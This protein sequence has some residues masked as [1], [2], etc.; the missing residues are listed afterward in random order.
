[1]NAVLKLQNPNTHESVIFSI[2]GLNEIIAEKDG[3]IEEQKNKIEKQSKN[4]EEKDK[5][6]EEQSIEIKDLKDKLSL[7]SENSSLP[8]S[9]DLYK[10]KKKEKKAESITEEEK[11]KGPAFGKSSGC[12]KF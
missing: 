8:S 6:I 2:K 3:S 9:R 7:N 4:I 12:R 1:M 5:I 10:I 11:K